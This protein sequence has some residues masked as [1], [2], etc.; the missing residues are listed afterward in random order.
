VLEDILLRALYT[1]IEEFTLVLG[2]DM[3]TIALSFYLVK[4]HLCENTSYTTFSYPITQGGKCAVFTLQRLGFEVD[5]VYSVQFSNHTGDTQSWILTNH[6][7]YTLS[8]ILTCRAEICI[9]HIFWSD[10]TEVCTYVWPACI[11]GYPTF[12][13]FVFDGKHL[14]DL[15]DGLEVN[16]LT[17]YSHL[18][19]GWGWRVQH[20]LA[21][22][23]ETK[24]ASI[25]LSYL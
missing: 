2:L 4:S 6:T 25:C 3:R 23:T 16:Q 9:S 10:C 1:N 24:Q 22:R 11:V 7:G 20:D 14:Q 13:G 12:K 21:I 8:W 19:T 17:K 18:L 5:P 15:L